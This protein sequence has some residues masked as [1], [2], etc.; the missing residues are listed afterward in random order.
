MRSST[1]FILCASLSTCTA[2]TSPTRP[3]PAVALSSTVGD[4]VAKGK[5]EQGKVAFLKAAYPV[6]SAAT[7]IAW[8]ACA[9]QALGTH[10][11]LAL[12]PLHT[13][14]TIAQAL[15][16]LP[17]LWAACDSL[18]AA[19]EVGWSR[20]QSATYRRLN[21]ALC[22]SSLWLAS[23]CWFAPAF[24][25][26]TTVT[27]A[28]KLKAAATAAHLAT[29]GVCAGAWLESSPGS[30]L[31]APGRVVKGVAGLMLSL[32]PPGGDEL[33]DPDSAAA[34]V[35]GPAILT[36]AL[37]AWTFAALAAP[38]PTATLP[39]ALGRRLSRAAG[40]HTLLACVAAYCVRDGEVRGRSDMSTFVK[41]RNG[42]RAVG[43]L[44]LA[45][46]VA[47]LA[48]D[49]WS[50]YPAASTRPILTAASI[51]TYAVAAAL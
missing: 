17:L 44:H 7:T 35:V 38:F 39:Y 28:C 14:L 30:L 48:F 42:L 10:P 41:L 22:A 31:Q 25:G 19:A 33:A 29:A 24:T 21:L 18:K 1:A 16:P 11:R 43:V 23:A 9:M 13:R 20:L 37:G 47:K 36:A 15:V 27:Y 49:D 34:K 3:R 2:F 12:P 45:M 32:V 50:Q 46:L 51:A 26:A 5:A 8:T 40:A 4:V 6:A